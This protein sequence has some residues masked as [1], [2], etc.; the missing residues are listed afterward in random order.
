MARYRSETWFSGNDVD[1]L[2]HRAWIRSE[3]FTKEVLS[4]SAGY[5][6][7]QQLERTQQL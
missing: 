5:R 3:G 4:G 7:R 6:H 2:M 1:A